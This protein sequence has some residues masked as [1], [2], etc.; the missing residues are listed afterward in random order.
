MLSS[1][2]IILL[3]LLS[4]K[5][6]AT[7]ETDN[8]EESSLLGNKI[9][10]SNFLGSRKPSKESTKVAEDTKTSSDK[11]SED[12]KLPE[13]VKNL[14][15]DKSVEEKPAD[16]PKGFN[17]ESLN[18]EVCENSKECIEKKC[19]KEAAASEVKPKKVDFTVCTPK[20]EKCNEVCKCEEDEIKKEVNEKKKDE[21]SNERNM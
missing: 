5:V 18:N 8:N 19:K 17:T 7:E 12:G 11:K 15:M 4:S 10:S 1:T 9:N 20:K 21:R 14:I 13:D 2:K 16:E 3:A 6:F